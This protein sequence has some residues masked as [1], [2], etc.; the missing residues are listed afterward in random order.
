MNV[1]HIDLHLLLT[2]VG[3]FMSRCRSQTLLIILIDRLRLSATEK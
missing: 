1:N 3:I 2:R